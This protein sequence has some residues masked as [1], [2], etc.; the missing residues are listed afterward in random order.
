MPI[1]ARVRS[2]GECDHTKEGEDAEKQS[3]IFKKMVNL[4]T[5]VENVDNTLNYV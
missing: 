2:G 5:N 4:V 1:G 3:S